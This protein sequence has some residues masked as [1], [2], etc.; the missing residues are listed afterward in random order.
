MKR[1]F[2]ACLLMF[3]LFWQ[4]MGCAGAAVLMASAADQLHASL[5][6]TGEAHHHADDDQAELQID[7]SQAS[8]QHLADDACVH[9]PALPPEALTLTHDLA[10]LAPLAAPT[11]AVPLPFL[12][13]L[14]RPP[15]LNS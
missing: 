3:C 13:G 10:P 12:P 2:T 15:R 14:E 11:G 4:S 8:A 9:A 7:D 1:R 5:H 6:F